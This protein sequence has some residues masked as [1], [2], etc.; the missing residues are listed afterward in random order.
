MII[1]KSIRPIASIGIDI[2][3]TLAPQRLFL[4][5]GT[6]GTVVS[7]TVCEVVRMSAALRHTLSNCT[8][9]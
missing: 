7:S 9:N 3:G 2:G 5:A 8:V 1:F 6:N 4:E